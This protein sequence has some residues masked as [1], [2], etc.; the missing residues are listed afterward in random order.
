MKKLI[1]FIISLIVLAFQGHANDIIGEWSGTLEVQGTP[2]TIIFHIAE[3]DGI[4]KTTMDSPDQGAKGLPTDET[5]FENQKLSISSE[6]MYMLYE[7]ELNKEGNELTGTFN[8]GPMELP[9]NLTKAEGE[10]RSN[11]RPQDPVDFPYIQEEVTFKNKTGGNHQLAGTLTMPENN[12]FEKVVI[13]V[14][15]SGPQNRDEEVAQFNHRPF[16]VLSDH[17]TRNGIAVLRYD[18]RGVNESEGDYRTAT[19]KDFA[20][21]VDAA[22]S[23]LCNRKD[24]KNKQIGIAGHSEGGM[25]APIVA[26]ENKAVDFIVLLAGPGTAIPELLMAQSEKIGKAEGAPPAVLE[27]N[28]KILGPAYDY[29]KSNPTHDKDQL[30]KSLFQIIDDNFD[31]FP[32]ETKKEIGADRKSFIES[33]VNTLT[34][35]W[36]LYFLRFEPAQYLSKVKCPVLAINGSLDLQVPAKEN[37]A[38]IK[39][40][41]KKA[42]NK[43]VTIKEFE[44]QNHLFQEAKTGA[45][46]EYKTIEETFNEGTME[47]ISNWINK[48]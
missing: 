20:S 41:L 45:P 17:L 7:A 46:S 36:F 9:L 11:L 29:I 38:A 32:E 22:V 6:K 12:K 21:D 27:A 30:S 2:L 26:S 25:I 10:G 34:S 33:Q 47:Y 13:L 5:T 43:Q 28:A 39:A 4:Y 37:L 42:K 14:S 35:D 18:D 40:A 8:Q 1:I 16:L 23:Y 24:M 44:N 48:I 19:S 15:G 3:E 31:F